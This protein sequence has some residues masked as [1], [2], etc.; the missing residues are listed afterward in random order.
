MIDEGV[1]CGM[2]GVADEGV[3]CC[4]RRGK[5]KSV[6]GIGLRWCLEG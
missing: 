4:L 3:V 5:V 6:D 1:V 2:G